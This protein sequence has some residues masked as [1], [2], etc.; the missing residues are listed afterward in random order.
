[1][2]N[3]IPLENIENKILLIRGQ[4][5]MLDRDLSSFYGVETRVL[6][7]AVKRNNKRF[8]K[9]FV[10]QLIKME[11]ESMVSQNVIPS[12]R[13]MGGRMPYVFT[14]QGVAMLSSVLKSEKAIEINVLIMRA[15]VN[16]RKLVYS[17]KDLAD[18]IRKIEKEQNKNFTEIFKILDVLMSDDPSTSS[19]QG[20]NN[21]IKEIGF[22]C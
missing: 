3:L 2:N 1:M 6:L 13:S 7:Q 9:D 5:V 14:E 15:F 22:K 20:K 12:R 18:K 8:P 10:F 11:A 19:G 21:K 16:I 4:K 17:Y